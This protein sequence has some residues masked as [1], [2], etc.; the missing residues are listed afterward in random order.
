MQ[1]GQEGS[2]EVNE[3]R[4]EL[5]RLM[6]SRCG[7]KMRLWRKPMSKKR[8]LLKISAIKSLKTTRASSII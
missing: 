3:N 4:A 2:G 5:I 6:Q 1:A 8:D 7:G